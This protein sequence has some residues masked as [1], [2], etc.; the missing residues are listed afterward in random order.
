MRKDQ[1]VLQLWPAGEPVV[2][3]QSGLVLREWTDQD[4]P[5]MVALFDTPEMDRRTPLAS[6]FDAAAA[7]AY[8]AAAHQVRR[9][10]G[11]LQL[12]ITEDGVVPKGEVLIFPAGSAGQVELAYGVGAVYAGRGLA[13][14]AVMVA[15][16]LA[17]ASGTTSARL[18]IALDNP[19][20][21]RVAEATGF[22]RQDDQPTVERHRKEQVLHL[23]VWQRTLDP[24]LLPLVGM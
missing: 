9:R 13:R 12:A 18:H 21:Q 4:V 24:A 8:V 11:A 2:I 19:A 6:P 7:A 23:A 20:S 14:R 17:A 5:A 3:D 15:L 10:L 16:R 22:A 1:P